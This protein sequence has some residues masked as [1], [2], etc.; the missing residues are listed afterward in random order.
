MAGRK[1]TDEQEE[2]HGGPVAGT[3]H[4]H[5]EGCGFNSGRGTKILQAT[6]C[7]QKKRKGDEQ[8]LR[9]L[10][11]KCFGSC[12]NTILYFRTYKSVDSLGKTER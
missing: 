6:W 3:L 9:A 1:S 10:H 7:G 12:R 2:F 11:E 4:S 8:G 5:C